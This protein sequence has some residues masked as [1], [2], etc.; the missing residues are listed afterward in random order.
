MIISHA[1]E[2]MMK[3]HELN[4]FRSR[5]RCYV[6]HG[7]L[8]GYQITRTA[9]DKSLFCCLLRC[10]FYCPSFILLVCHFVAYAVL[11]QFRH[12]V[13]LWRFF[14]H[15]SFSSFSHIP[16]FGNICWFSFLLIFSILLIS[17]ITLRTE[18]AIQ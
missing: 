15:S 12:F 8:Y 3:P 7:L 5:G 16:Y 10:L 17:Q 18:I 14:G 13:L 1:G 6:I 11:A 4:F 2:D 9:G